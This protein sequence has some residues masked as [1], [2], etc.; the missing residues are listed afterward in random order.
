[1][2]NYASE[3]LERI[4]G[5]HTAEIAALLGGKDYDEVIHRDNLVTLDGGGAVAP[6]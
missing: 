5:R 1:L 2:S 3:A 6:G 4:R